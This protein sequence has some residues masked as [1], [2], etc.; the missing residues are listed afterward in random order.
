MNK[1][2]RWQGCTSGQSLPD[3]YSFQFEDS[4]RSEIAQSVNLAIT[5][6]ESGFFASVPERLHLAI[7]AQASCAVYRKVA[8]KGFNG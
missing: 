3:C 6:L 1:R 8:R 2:F 4:Y 7:N 5:V